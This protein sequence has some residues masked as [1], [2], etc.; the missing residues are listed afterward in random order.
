MRRTVAFAVVLLMFVISAGAVHA[1]SRVQQSST[2]AEQLPSEELVVTIPLSFPN[3]QI[4]RV[5]DDQVRLDGLAERTR[6]ELSERS[7]QNIFVRADVDVPL[8]NLRSVLDE[9][10]AGGARSVGII[11]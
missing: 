7:N 4:V 11:K 6:E 3:D 2:A 5:G 10:R 1:Q 9:L 8:E